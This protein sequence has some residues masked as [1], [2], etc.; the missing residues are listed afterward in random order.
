MSLGPTR[1]RKKPATLS[2]VAG[3]CHTPVQMLDGRG[4]YTNPNDG[5]WVAGAGASRV[6]EAAPPR[7]RTCGRLLDN[8]AP[9]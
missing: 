2:R 8:R 9:V 7:R 3:K 1:L 6:E 5:W 4:L